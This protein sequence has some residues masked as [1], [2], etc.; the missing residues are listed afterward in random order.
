M[1]V[2]GVYLF[3]CYLIDGWFIIT[4]GLG[5]FLLNGFIGFLSPLDDP[6]QDGP[7]LPMSDTE[8]FRPFNRKVGGGGV[9][10][11]RERLCRLHARSSTSLDLK[12]GG[13]GK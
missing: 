4:Y 6:E 12:A 5:I 13:R 1:L 3:R 7:T 9:H 10:T 8:E 2:L 11:H